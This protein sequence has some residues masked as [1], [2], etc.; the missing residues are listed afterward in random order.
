MHHLM[1]ASIE[2]GEKA[3]KVKWPGS[4]TVVAA[5]ILGTTEVGGNRQIY[6]DRLI[7]R[8]YETKVGEYQVE[9]AVSSIL[10]IPLK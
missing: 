2:V 3:I 1:D 6:L 5:E 4:S 9:G 10:T 8:P 7:H